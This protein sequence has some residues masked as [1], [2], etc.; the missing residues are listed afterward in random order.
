MTAYCLWSVAAWQ[1]SNL[2]V[3]LWKQRRA[4]I[5]KTGFCHHTPWQ[6]AACLLCKG[7]LSGEG[8][9]QEKWHSR[10]GHALGDAVLMSAAVTAAGVMRLL[11]VR[12]MMS[13]AT[14]A[15]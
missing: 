4:V 2:Q 11:A 15:T 8:T 10:F 1:E 5:C 3:V 14:P 7:K 9:G 12:L 6:L 13:A